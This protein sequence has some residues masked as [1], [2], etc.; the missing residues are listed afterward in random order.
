MSLSNKSAPLW[1]LV[2]ASGLML[3]VSAFT[4]TCSSLTN[5]VLT[6]DSCPSS[7]GS[8]PCV[9]FSP[10]LEDTKPC[11]AANAAGECLNGTDYT[12][13]GTTTTCNIT[14]QCL[15]SI[16][17]TSNKQWLLALQPITNSDSYT[18]AWVTEIQD[19]VFQT[20]N[21]MTSL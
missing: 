6:S 19:L 15:N 13:P 2:A 9:L 11:L 16:V 5:N 14:Y 1:L 8:F 10:S 18:V 17:L 3:S 4:N 20:S 12:L 7:C 21:T